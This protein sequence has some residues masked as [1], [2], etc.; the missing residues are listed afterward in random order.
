M[1]VLELGTGWSLQGQSDL[2][3]ST[4]LNCFHNYKVKTSS[5]GPWSSFTSPQ[6]ETGQRMS[7]MH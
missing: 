3:E 5:F 1:E 7:V 2:V 6:T 4:V